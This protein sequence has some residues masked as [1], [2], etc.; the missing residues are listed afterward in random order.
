VLEVYP[1][2]YHKTDKKGRPIY[3]ERQGYT[4]MDKLFKITTEERL[5]RHYI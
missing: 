1:H 2:A 5:L 4:D 3:I